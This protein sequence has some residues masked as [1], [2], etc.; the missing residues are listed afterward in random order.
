MFLIF[1]IPGLFYFLWAVYALAGGLF[2]LWLILLLAYMVLKC[3]WFVL[4]ATFNIFH[5]DMG[6]TQSAEAFCPDGRGFSRKSGW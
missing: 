1:F 5:D 4:K 3:A 6:Q 2:M